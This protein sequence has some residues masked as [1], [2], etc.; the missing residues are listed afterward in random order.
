[1]NPNIDITNAH[2][3]TYTK[4]NLPKVLFVCHYKDDPTEGTTAVI[5]SYYHPTLLAD[6]LG[7]ELWKEVRTKISESFKKQPS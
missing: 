6:A 1:M 7:P 2:L 4:P 3:L 5:D